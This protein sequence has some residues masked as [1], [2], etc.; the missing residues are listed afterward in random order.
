MN[1]KNEIKAFKMLLRAIPATVVTDDKTER[2]MFKMPNNTSVTVSTYTTDENSNR[3]FKDKAWMNEDGL[4]E[5][6]VYVRRDNVWKLAG[7]LE[8]TVE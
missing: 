1:L 6:K 4:N 7:T 5:I 2:V 8:Y 3:V